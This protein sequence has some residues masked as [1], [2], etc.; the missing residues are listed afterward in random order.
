MP[1]WK[2]R[3]AFQILT[4]TSTFR[5]FSSK[6]VFTCVVRGVYSRERES[7]YPVCRASAEYSLQNKA[8]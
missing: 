7:L 4:P 2:L 1:R 6:S 3:P 5:L 8:A